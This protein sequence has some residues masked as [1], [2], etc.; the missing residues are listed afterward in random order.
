MKNSE[1]DDLLTE[2]QK[3]SDALIKAKKELEENSSL[4]AKMSLSIKL[5]KELRTFPSQAIGSVV[6]YNT[7]N[8]KYDQFTTDQ[9]NKIVRFLSHVE[10]LEKKYRDLYVNCTEQYHVNPNYIPIIALRK[11][12]KAIDLGYS[13][14]SILVNEVQGD[15]VKFNQVYNK[16]E[17]EGLFM[18]VPEKRTQE[19]L[20]DISSKMDN[21]ING[22]K[23]LFQT[24][25][26]TNR[27]L[28][29]IE[30]GIADVASINYG[31]SDQLWDI[32][33]EVSK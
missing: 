16:L 19:Y 18:T 20:G 23:V 2:Y 14:L 26:E 10:S 31:I 5:E 17:D 11:E 12:R 7:L 13:L 8:E 22:L 4:V 9:F 15:L 29:E 1:I 25:Q 33:F 32:S 28:R 30:G 27:A 21:V 3:T 6:L 24:L